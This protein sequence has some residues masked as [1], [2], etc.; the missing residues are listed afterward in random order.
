MIWH[1][2]YLL[3]NQAK[4]GQRQTQKGKLHLSKTDSS[5]CQCRWI[6]LRVEK[7]INN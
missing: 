6:R 2:N 7:H 3:L 1:N 5:L 4:L